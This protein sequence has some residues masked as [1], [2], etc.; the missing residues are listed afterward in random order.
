MINR[1]EGVGASEIAALFGCHPYLSEYGLWARKTGLVEDKPSTERLQN[2]RDFE[3]PI[4]EIWS[5]RSGV[6]IV[7]NSSAD[8]LM[9]PPGVDISTLAG[10]MNIVK[11]ERTPPTITQTQRTFQSP[12]C[13]RL[14]AT[15][16]AWTL[17]HA[18]REH[19]HEADVDAK[20]VRPHMIKEWRKN[21]T[22][23]YYKLQLRA[24]NACT[25]RSGAYLVAA[26]G[27]D[28]I[29][30]EFLPADIAIQDEICRRVDQ[31][32][33][34]VEGKLP[35][36]D[37]DGSESTKTALMATKR[38]EETVSLAGDIAVIDSR[39][40]Q[41]K[42]NESD[43]SKRVKQLQAEIIKALG[44]A[45]R[46]VFTDGSGYR[47]Q[48]VERAPYTAKASKYQKLVRF[49]GDDSEEGDE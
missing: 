15:P 13:S 16:D 24:Q 38:N 45:N 43:W 47:V 9:V 48:I 39:L 25:G 27:W 2:G 29:S 42:A 17:R 36:P 40:L 31:F 10:G 32:W 12:H 19:S 18:E 34:R 28:E 41:A 35:P 20:T 5:R 44:N 21:G 49:T 1:N 46:G 23:D 4:L 6:P 33:L 7:I 26:F 14:F 30:H 3:V 22:P 11:Y 8:T 37:V